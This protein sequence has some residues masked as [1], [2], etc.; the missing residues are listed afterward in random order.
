[1]ISGGTPLIV[2]NKAQPGMTEISKADFESSIERKINSTVPFDLKAASNAAKLGQTFAEANR[3]TKAGQAMRD[4]AK[5]IVG[6][7]EDDGAA[8][9]QTGAT[10]SLLGKIGRAHV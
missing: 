7:S 1:P 3:S 8:L 10:T 4:I 9:N 6:V 5:A 2:A